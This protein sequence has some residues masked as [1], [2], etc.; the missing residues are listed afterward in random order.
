MTSAGNPPFRDAV[1][2]QRLN[3]F[4]ARVK[5]DGKIC[6]VHVPNTGRLAEL[7]L[8]GT[9]VVLVPSPGKYPYRI[10]YVIYNSR[11]V[12]IDSIMSNAIFRDCIVSRAMP[13]LEEFQIVRREP[14]VGNHRF[15]YS[16]RHDGKD[17]FVEIKSC[18]LAW[19]SLASFP[20][21][22][23]ARAAEHVRVLAETKRGILVFI[24]LHEGIQLF[25]P[26]YHTDFAFYETLRRHKNDIE[27]RAYSARYERDYRIT[28]MAPVRIEIPD[29]EPRG[30]Y[31]LV[32]RAGSDADLSIGSLGAMKFRKGYYIYVGSGMNNLFKRIE[33]HRRKRK[34]PHWHIDY[35]S[36]R[37]PVAAAL[38]IVT[39]EKLECDLAR[40][41]GALGYRCIENFGSSD[42]AC[43]GHLYYGE[44]DP[45]HDER[46][47]AM[48][49][50][51]RYGRMMRQYGGN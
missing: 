12:L 51:Y 40:S 15:D 31:A 3:R 20:D 28:G 6:S 43:P 50:E 10:Q 22:V 49:Y 11:P 9:R 21:A 44:T 24:L 25:V 46:F 19:N 7:F 5:L 36:V 17:F 42:C 33:Y 47:I 37:F 8:P 35:L 41:V 2:L 32:L 38:P 29:V 16:V 23:S 13:G 26:N 18:T 14:T 48:I 30:I 4:V 45:L 39:G 27:M 34:E 1:F